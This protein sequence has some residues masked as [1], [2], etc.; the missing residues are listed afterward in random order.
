MINFVGQGQQMTDELTELKKISKLLILAHC[1]AIEKE[2]SK[3][4]TTD[5]RK[6]IWVLIDGTKLP[7]DMVSQIGNITQRA[8]EIF[9]D[10][11]EKAQLITN[12]KRKPAEKLLDYVPPKWIEL[13]EKDKKA[14]KDDSRRTAKRAKLEN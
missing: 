13:L 8:I 14:R 1:E 3:Y 12:P 2:L 4:A 5:E 7:R 6:K 9:L 11:L 10:E